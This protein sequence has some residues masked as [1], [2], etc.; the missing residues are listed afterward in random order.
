MSYSLEFR[1]E[2]LSKVDS[3]IPVNKVADL[4]GI[5]RRCIPVWRKKLKETGSLQ[6]KARSARSG[7][8]IDVSRLAE[9]VKETPDATIK[10]LAS[11]FS[12]QTFAVWKQLKK[13]GLTRKKNHAV[14]GKGRKKA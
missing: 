8:K 11:V 3:G 1:K 7:G 14:C 6:D 4:F 9:L 13:L 12:C 2:V 10:E 5:S